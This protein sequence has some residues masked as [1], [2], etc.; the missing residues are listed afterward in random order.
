MRTGSGVAGPRVG[1][2][3]AA[4]PTPWRAHLCGKGARPGIVVYHLILGEEATVQ[5][6]PPS[7]PDEVGDLVPN[8]ARLWGGEETGGANVGSTRPEEASPRPAEQG[9]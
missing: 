8:H 4:M 1:G 5:H 7:G 9:G 2:L 3:E 6:V